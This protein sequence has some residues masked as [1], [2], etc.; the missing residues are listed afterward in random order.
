[1][2]VSQ[3]MKNKT[4]WKNPEKILHQNK[5]IEIVSMLLY[6]TLSIMLSTF[7][8]LNICRDCM[9]DISLIKIRVYSCKE[10]ARPALNVFTVAKSAA[11]YLCST[12]G[13]GY[14]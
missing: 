2:K 4:S 14:A 13:S 8:I 6:Y 7:S 10:T 1:M 5:D 9:G 12:N 11:R 3:N